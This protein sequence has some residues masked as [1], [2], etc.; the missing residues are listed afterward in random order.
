MITAILRLAFYVAIGPV[1][2]A[3][4]GN[5]AIAFAIA[6]GWAAADPGTGPL[7]VF[8]GFLS[9]ENLTQA[10]RVGIVPMV[11]IG[12]VAI[13]LSR[14]LSGMRQWFAVAFGGAS[15]TAALAWFAYVT[16]PVGDGF[17]PFLFAG[18][19]AFAGAV[20]GFLCALLFDL[21]AGLLRARP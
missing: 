11:A 1:L 16:A 17:N 8:T 19:A 21:V 9:S 18:V 6:F 2:L 10:Y 5:I 13:L 3:A 4:A 12:I 7:D 15:I 20:A 14:A